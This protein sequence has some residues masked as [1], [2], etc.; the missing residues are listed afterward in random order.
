MSDS[1]WMKGDKELGWNTVLFKSKEKNPKLFSHSTSL[2]AKWRDLLKI[3]VPIMQKSVQV[4]RI[5][6][7]KHLKPTAEV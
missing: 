3:T 7:N 2:W 1:T 4:Y 6:N 5:A